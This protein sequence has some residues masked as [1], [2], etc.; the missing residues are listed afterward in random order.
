MVAV[1][2]RRRAFTLIELLV[3]IAIIAVLIGLLLPVDSYVVSG[4]VLAAL[5]VLSANGSAA[6]LVGFRQM[7]AAGGCFYALAARLRREPRAPDLVWPALGAIL[8]LLSACAIGFAL[9]APQRFPAA[10]H[11]LDLR[12]GSVHGLTRCL[13]VLSVL[14]AG[15]AIERGAGLLWRAIATVGIAGFGLSVAIGRSGLALDV[16][17]LA[18]LDEPFRFATSIVVFLLIA[19]LTL[20]AWQLAGIRAREAGRWRATG[21]V[22]PLLALFMLFG[23]V[24][25]GE[26]IRLVAALAG[27]AV[28]AGRLAPAALRLQVA[29]AAP[30]EEPLA[31]AA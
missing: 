24:G 3:V 26:E 27:A 6:A 12:W 18:R 22:F 14:C 25:G 28:V 2:F 31:R 8:L 15:R 7:A 16:A 1:P 10:L 20:L 4:F 9:A 23:G 17:S 21:V 11:E 30:A 13:C 5:Q 29:P 19:R